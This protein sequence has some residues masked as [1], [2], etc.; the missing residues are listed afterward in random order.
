M[1]R[2]KII[3]AKQK[4]DQSKQEIDEVAKSKE[5]DVDKFRDE[6]ASLEKTIDAKTLAKYKTIKQ[7]GIMPVFVPLV[8][9][10][11]GGCRMELSVSAL[12][13]LKES[14]IY[15]CEQCRR[16]IYLDEKK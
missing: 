6:L 5:T 14:G 2:K 16:L 10:R 12:D 9:K 11:C 13:K 1:Y 15:E 4:R 8:D 3:E 7:D